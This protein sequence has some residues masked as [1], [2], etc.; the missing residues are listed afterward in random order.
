TEGSLLTGIWKDIPLPLYERIYFFNI[1]NGEDFLKHGAPLNITEIGPYTYSARWVKRYPEWHSNGTVSYRETRTYH[2]EPQLSPGLE[3]EDIITTLNGPL[4]IAAEVLKKYNIWERIVAS[5][6]LGLAG[7]HVI[8]Q[9][10]VKELVY[11]GYPDPIMKVARFVLPDI[12]Y[13]DGRFSWLYGKNATND[14]LF[15]VFTGETDPQMTNII[16]RWNGQDKVTFWK[17]DSC[18]MIKG[19]SV[20]TGPPQPDVPESYTFFQSIFCRSLTFNYTEDVSHYG[21]LTKR[22]KP[23]RNVFA[24]GTENPD[25]YCFDIKERPSGVSDIKNCQ[26]G[27][28][29]LISWPHFYM[30]DPLYLKDINGLQPNEADHGS[31]LDADPITGIS[32]DVQVRFQI[33]LELSRVRGLVQFDDIPEGIFPVFWA[34]LEIQITD[35]WAHFLKGQIN[36]PKIIAYSV[37]G[38]LVLICLILIVVSLIVLRRTDDD[39]DDP[40]LDV[41]EEHKQNLSKKVIV[42]NYNSSGSYKEGTSGIKQRMASKEAE[43]SNSGSINSSLPKGAYEE[44]DVTVIPIDPSTDKTL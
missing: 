35:D 43:A 16:N 34:G 13:Q 7:E 28:P 20:E 5:G 26:F 6:I 42:P 27:A 21:V 10:S 24:N 30:A 38:S 31:H 17:N 4:I 1:T 41:K 33:N 37:L 11:E 12:P 14:G 39:D 9:K 22:F 18:N 29:A 32:L 44:E 23:T 2:F 25:N 40:L 19:T 3:E 36:N 15:T 8:I